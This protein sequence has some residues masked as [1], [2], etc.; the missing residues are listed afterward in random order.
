[1]KNTIAERVL[2][3]LKKYPPFDIISKQDLLDIAKETVIV[4]LEKE[5]VLFDEDQP[6]HPHFL[7]CKRRCHFT[8]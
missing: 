5:Q 4:Y 6:L 3:F 7:H 2:E 8:D 1:M